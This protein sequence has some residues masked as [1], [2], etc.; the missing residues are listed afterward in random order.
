MSFAAVHAAHPWDDALAG[1]QRQPRRLQVVGEIDEHHVVLHV[2]D[3]GPG[4]PLEH[5]EGVFS[6][7]KTSKTDGMGVGLWLSQSIVE[8]HGGQLSFSSDLGQGCTFS[9]KLPRAEYVLS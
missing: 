8:T 5:Q 6:L 2:I 7:F 1:V 9:L 3:N 4:I